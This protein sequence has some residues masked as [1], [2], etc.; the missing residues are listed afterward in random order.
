VHGRDGT[1]LDPDLT[2]VIV[3]N[4]CSA[5]GPHHDRVTDIGVG[6]TGNG[7]KAL[8]LIDGQI[9]V[10]RLDGRGRLATSTAQP[11]DSALR[12]SLR[13]IARKRSK[14]SSRWMSPAGPPEGTVLIN[15]FGINRRYRA[16]ME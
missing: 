5:T 4:G 14:A 6:R 1:W 3:D 16:L 9:A 11:I 7:L 8:A 10:A 2:A 15:W 13:L 12:T